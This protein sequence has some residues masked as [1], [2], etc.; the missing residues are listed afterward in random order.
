METQ[1]TK[2]EKSNRKI[3]IIA[4]LKSKNLENLLPSIGF[5]QLNLVTSINKEIFQ[6]KQQIHHRLF[7]WNKTNKHATSR[8]GFQLFNEILSRRKKEFLKLINEWAGNDILNWHH[9]RKNNYG[10]TLINTASGIEQ[11]FFLRILILAGAEIN[12]VDLDGT[13][14]VQIAAQG[15]RT[16]K[17][18]LLL[19]AGAKLDLVT[20]P[21]V[22]TLVHRAVQEGVPFL[23]MVVSAGA[24]FD[25][26]DDHGRTPVHTA[27]LG[28]FVGCLKFLVEVRAKLDERDSCENTAI[29]MSL[30]RMIKSSKCW[31]HQPY[32]KLP[33]CFK[34]LLSAGAK[35]DLAQNPSWCT[36]CVRLILDRCTIHKFPQTTA[37]HICVGSTFFAMFFFI[38]LFP[39]F[40]SKYFSYN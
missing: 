37:L 2:Q 31:K 9:P 23:R 12:H 28:E 7:S 18:K 25:Q 17:L 39:F 10:S 3:N 22:Q 36:E 20:H 32:R 8:V 38:F 33:E 40:F 1:S 21:C 34:I 15:K 4:L 16:E 29:Q 19:E 11:C 35:F 24:N 5:M 14:P 6:E 27:V 13:S 30:N 26:V